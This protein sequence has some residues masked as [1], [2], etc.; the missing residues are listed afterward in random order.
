MVFQNKSIK[1]MSKEKKI[2]IYKKIKE[3][4]QKA[5]PKER[6]PSSW[7]APIGG[8]FYDEKEVKAVLECYFKGWLSVQKK[9]A[10][11]EKAF[12]DYIGVRYGVATNS[13]TSA[14]ILALASLIEANDL[15][16]GDEVI[17]PATTFITVATPIIQ[18]GLIPV[19]VDVDDQTFNINPKELEKSINPKKTKAV[20]VVHCY[21]QA[22]ELDP[23]LDFARQH[24]LLV[25]EDAA[26]L[27]DPQIFFPGLIALNYRIFLV[28]LSLVEDA[29]KALHFFDDTIINKELLLQADIAIETIFPAPITHI[30]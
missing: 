6:R 12:A 28:K 30:A 25:I 17:V 4:F 1:T 13:G 15:K 24:N 10:E 29:F 14:N 21:G 19:Y 11:F 3:Y 26:V 23:I 27:L 8:S 5:D 7:R 16:I 20:M 18:L 9:V 22:S 2:E